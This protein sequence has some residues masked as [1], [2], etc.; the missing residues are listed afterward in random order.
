MLLYTAPWKNNTPLSAT[1]ALGGTSGRLDASQLC[2][3]AMSKLPA[4]TAKPKLQITAVC[5]QLDMNHVSSIRHRACEHHLRGQTP[6]GCTKSHQTALGMCRQAARTLYGISYLSVCNKH[7]PEVGCQSIT[8]NLQL[9][10][11]DTSFPS[12]QTVVHAQGLDDMHSCLAHSRAC[13]RHNKS[14]HCAVL[15]FHHM[16]PDCHMVG[17]LLTPTAE[18][19]RKDSAFQRQLNEKP[20][21][22]PGTLGT[23]PHALYMLAPHTSFGCMGTMEMI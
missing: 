19:R 9:I 21:I 17:A 15:P 14:L 13:L 3:S 22:I 8:C 16:H 7:P 18:E 23:A 12:V 2:T 1:G 11:G 20:S 6:D 10:H 4:G 5:M